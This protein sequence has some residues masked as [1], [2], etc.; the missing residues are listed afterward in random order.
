M[1]DQV[2][3]WLEIFSYGSF[4]IFFEFSEYTVESIRSY[5]SVR[6]LRGAMNKIVGIFQFVGAPSQFE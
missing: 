6:L 4:F 3:N 1:F 5:N 2:S